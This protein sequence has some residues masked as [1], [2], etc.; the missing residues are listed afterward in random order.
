VQWIYSLRSKLILTWSNKKNTILARKLKMNLYRILDETN[1]L[2]NE[3]SQRGMARGHLE[4]VE[5]LHPE[6]HYRINKELVERNYKPEYIQSN[7]IVNFG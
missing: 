2:V 7:L 1:Y 4:V 3:F 5:Q 6:H